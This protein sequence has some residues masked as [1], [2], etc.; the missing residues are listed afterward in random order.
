MLNNFDYL[1]PITFGLIHSIEPDHLITVSALAIDKENLKDSI[2][3]G[4]YWGI[5]H[6][7]ILLLVSNL[8]TF[9]ISF[10]PESSFHRTEVLV[11]LMMIVLGAIRIYKSQKINLMKHPHSHSFSLIAGLLHGFSGSAA[12]VTMS[13][14]K[15]S[16]SFDKYIFLTMFGISSLVS[17]CVA[18]LFIKAFVNKKILQNENFKKRL[19][20]LTGIVC[21]LYGV[22]ILVKHLRTCE[23][24]FGLP[25]A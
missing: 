16:E 15:Y 19:I 1:F 8:F 13:L 14:P 20:L 2:K 11:S 18:I 23:V 12:V 24:C 21:L 4:I 3:D 10:L 7:L 6:F 9:V 22:Y 25:H 5:G 17:M